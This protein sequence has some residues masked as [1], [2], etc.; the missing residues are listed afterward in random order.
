MAQEKERRKRARERKKNPLALLYLLVPPATQ[1][2][3]QRGR[4]G[5]MILL[6]DQ[7]RLGRDSGLFNHVNRVRELR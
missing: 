6:R 3:T 2:R 4:G 1:Q 5:N 7:W